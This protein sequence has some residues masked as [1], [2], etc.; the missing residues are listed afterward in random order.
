MRLQLVSDVPLG[1]FLSGGVDSSAVVALMA[2]LSGDKV[3]T[4]SIAFDDREYDE[5][6]YARLVAQAKRT[7]HS[8]KR[9]E[10]DD[11]SLLERLVDIYDEPYA[12]QFGDPHLS[13]LCRRAGASHGGAFR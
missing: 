5:S 7:E 11:F 1:A 9:V 4:C 12:G 3:R 13:G 6:R 2:E 8:E 10:V